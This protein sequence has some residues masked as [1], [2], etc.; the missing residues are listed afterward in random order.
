MAKRKTIEVE[1]I[2]R[3]I[4]NLLERSDDT[5]PGA[6]AK[7]TLCSLLEGILHDTGNYRGFNYVYW[8]KRGNQEWVAAGKPEV[9]VVKNQFIIGDIGEWA[10]I[11]Y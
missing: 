1:E 11:Y 9:P 7:K 3:K 5:A 8:L 6:D 4:N 10:R 2:K